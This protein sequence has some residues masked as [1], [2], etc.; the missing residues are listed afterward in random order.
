MN[1]ARTRGSRRAVAAL[2]VMA[3]MLG[4]APAVLANNITYN[5]NDST[6]GQSGWTI[7][8]SITVSQLGN[9]TQSDIVSFSWTATSGTTN[10]G[11]SGAGHLTSL[12]TS[13]TGTAH[14][15]ATST[16]LNV[17]DVTLFGLNSS[18]YVGDLSWRNNLFSSSQY[19]SIKI[20]TGP[21]FDSSTY[22]PTE[23]SAWTIGTNA[24]PPAPSN[25]PEI[26][27]ASCGS[28]LASLAGVIAMIEQRRR[29]R[30]AATAATARPSGS[31]E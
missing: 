16:S 11:G 12:S 13:G 4:S 3:G 25:V 14:L 28:A 29:R 6:A 20:P 5:L 17:P 19:R 2:L 10:F 24:V 7:S 30:G 21:I 1:V 26:D 18:P 27:P 22:S 31:V 9:I 8:G 15:E 23:G